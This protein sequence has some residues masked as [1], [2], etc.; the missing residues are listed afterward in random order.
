MNNQTITEVSRVTFISGVAKVRTPDGEVHDLKVGD[1][2]QPG[3][4]VIL[5]DASVFV[6]EA[7]APEATGAQMPPEAVAAGDLPADQ[8]PASPEMGSADD[9]TLAQIN[10][11]QQA[12]LA[13]ADPTEAFEAAAAGVAADAGGRGPGSGN[14]GFVSID[15]VGNATIAAAGYDTAA[16]H[17]APQAHF[18]EPAAL[19]PEEE[20]R[21]TL[22]AP[23]TNTVKED[24]PATGNVLANDSDPDD[25]L[26][27]ANFVINGQNFL[28]GSTASL[29]GIGSLIINVDGSYT[30]TPVSD[31]NGD[32]PQVTYTTNTGASSTL[33]INVTP[34]N[35]NPDAVNDDPE[36]NPDALTTKE[37]V[38]LTILPGILLANDSDIDGDPLSILSVQNA[39]NGSVS[40]VNGNV[41]FTPTADYN[42]P[43]SFTY[44]IS[45]GAGGTDTATVSI[46]VTPVND[47]PDA[48]NDDPEAN[49]DALTTKE[50]VPLTI[51]PATLLANDS[52]I[53][54]DPLSIVSVQNAVNGAVSL[55]NGN[56]VFTPATD[57]N[58]PASFTYTISDGKGGT[59]TATVTITITPDNDPPVALA[60]NYS[61]LEDHTLTVD[62][63][64]FDSLLLNDSDIDGDT[65]TVN[66][67]PV[68]DVAHGT[69]VLNEN[70][71]FTYTPDDNYNGTDSF[72]Y[73]VSDGKGGTDT[74][75]VTITIT[76]DND[77]PVALADNYSVLEDHTLTVDGNVFDSLLLNDSD[78]DGDT[79]TVNTTPVTDV[80]HGTLVL[81]GNGTFTYTP[82]DNYNGTDSFV[83]EVSD[84][85]GGTDTATVTITI[86]PDNDPP[87]ALADNYSVLEDHTLTVDGNVFDSLLLNDSDIDGDTLTVNTTPVTDV[88][89]GTLVLNENGTFTYTPDD[90]YNG[91]DSFVYEVSDGKGGTDTATVTI[92]ITPDNDPPVLDLDGNDSTATGFNYNTH[93]VAGSAPIS[94]GDFN[95][96]VITDPDVSDDITSATITLTN[97]QSGDVLAVGT[98]PAGIDYSISPDGWIVTLTGSASRDAYEQAIAAVTFSNTE[99]DLSSI[100]RT[101]DVVVND[102]DVDS[103]HATTTID[104]N[105]YVNVNIVSDMMSDDQT[106]QVTFTFSEAVTGFTQTDLTVTGGTVSMP[107]DSGD[108]IHWTA[109]F[110]PTP[111]YS[112]AAEVTVNSLSYADLAGNPG[113]SGTDT[114][115][116][117]PISYQDAD[118]G[119]LMNEIDSSDSFDMKVKGGNVT[120]A[121]NGVIYWDFLVRDADNNATITFGT[122]KLPDTIIPSYTKLYNADGTV[123]FRVYLTATASTTVT[124]SD[125]FDIYFHNVDADGT[126]GLRPTIVL[127]NSD[128]F[129]RPHNNY[130]TNY[131]S[132]LVFDTGAVT[133]NNTVAD[134]DWLSPYAMDD[135]NVNGGEFS[136]GTI[137]LQTGVTQHYYGGDDIVYGTTGHDILSGGNDH[138]FIAGR[139]GNDQLYGG[140]GN[141]TLVGGYGNDMLYGD[142]GNDIL[143]GGPSNDILNG[144]DG[145]DTAMYADATAGV[146]VN[147]STNSATGGDG[148]DILSNIENITGS[149]FDDSLTGNDGINVLNGGAGAD[150][151]TG[152]LGDDILTGGSGA[153]IFKWTAAD[154]TS[155]GAPF[156]DTITD[157][158]IDQ[159]DMLDLTDVL[160]NEPA[161]DLSNYLTFTTTSNGVEVSVHASGDINITDMTIVIQNPTD[162]LAELQ[163]YLQTGTGVIH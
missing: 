105:P 93:Y 42:G 60:D 121:T 162:T 100:N 9:Q 34:V 30:F 127:L 18:D 115:Y 72:V 126:D 17:A 116:I 52:D 44:T 64:V 1:I 69:L 161:N 136:T 56:V 151:L 96:I 67:T 124:P 109:T 130:N 3:T 80:A 61:V 55:V 76:P 154:I 6:V 84:G 37:D 39:V 35:D 113:S 75:T 118:T 58:G 90:N 41:V 63:N 29:D 137:E 2:L 13:G 86:T 119:W 40:L 147:L 139:A 78:I 94:I 103:N 26:S 54:G 14:S 27:V 148:T 111:G 157:F 15:R 123:V 43:A 68:T 97:P 53:D 22:V 33:D 138:D 125:Q 135:T 36:A 81:N 71:T 21:P 8:Q 155:S 57:Y 158:S 25:A 145:T 47:D 88:A 95:D 152:G 120:L 102:G 11:L 156:E 79:L 32:V 110:T 85:K 66:T 153:D 114:V 5:A 48:V 108:G 99:D 98:L 132:P 7:T 133:V 122:G 10:Q 4:E 46:D 104:I 74:A 45:D 82:D 20:N 73:E 83:Y 31:W 91:T 107:V 163:T 140:D 77:P 159:H 129:I 50:D 101:I 106:S 24:T 23:D 89:H 112:G 19:I 128:E 150:T 12:I 134:Q 149:N 160:T 117:S 62:G 59:D 49:P 92:T 141:D 16:Q 142:A 144:G 131:L 38:P 65:L 146:T 28:A 143:L 70:G 87:V 51:L